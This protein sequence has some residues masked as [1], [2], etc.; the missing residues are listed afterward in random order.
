[1]GLRIVKNKK[2]L[3]N[4]TQDMRLKSVSVVEQERERQLTIEAMRWCQAKGE[5]PNEKLGEFLAKFKGS[6]TLPALLKSEKNS[7][8]IADISRS[9]HEQNL[10]AFKDFDL[11]NLRELL[12]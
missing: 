3:K 4:Q 7:A 5:N 2:I 1:M 12:E 10:S 8:S 6:S 9:L 11:A